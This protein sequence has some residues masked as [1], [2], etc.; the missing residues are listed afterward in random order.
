MMRQLA[1]VC[2]ES[3]VVRLKFENLGDV[4]SGGLETLVLVKAGDTWK[5]R[6]SH[7]SARRRPAPPAP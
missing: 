3:P 6:H 4:D 7:T 2:D 1:F 5:I